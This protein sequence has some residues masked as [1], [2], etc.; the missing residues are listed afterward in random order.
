MIR[1]SLVLVALL[2]AGCKPAAPSAAAP[3]AGHDEHAAP[4]LPP[5]TVELSPAALKNLGVE[6]ATVERRR[7]N[8]LIALP[9]RFDPAPGGRVE[10]RA[11]SAGYL[12]WV[13][14]PFSQV[15]SGE[16]IAL[17]RSP[18]LTALLTEEGDIKS[19]SIQA[20]AK[21]KLASAQL[22]EA[23][24]LQEMRKNRL[25]QLRRLGASRAEQ[26]TQLAEGA[27]AL[28][29]L[30]AELE[31]ARAEASAL[32][33]RVKA[34]DNEV[35]SLAGRRDRIQ[36]DGS[37]LMAAPN[38]GLLSGADV[39]GAAATS[40]ACPDC[41]GDGVGL[42]VT[43]GQ[44]LAFINNERKLQLRVSARP[45]QI[46]GLNLESPGE[47]R[48]HDGHAFPGKLRLDP[49]ADSLTG[50]RSLVCI[51]DQAL[52]A[53]L[54]PGSPANLMVAGLG[55][56][57]EV[58]TIPDSALVRDGSELV[59]FRRDP[60]NPARIRRVVADLG[61]ISAGLAEIKSGLRT[62]DLVVAKGAYAVNLSAAA[63]KNSAPPGFHYHA[64]GQLHSD[65]AEKGGH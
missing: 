63:N 6:F 4:K 57:E 52:P 7:L 18:Q 39:A 29:R 35:I 37:L 23:R 36:E 27:L 12:R 14:K 19:Q 8:H 41:V 2:V 22:A 64:D 21:V 1:H 49:A 54:I 17:L 61:L 32:T 40:C 3:E 28:P 15:K 59:F 13:V 26:E 38:S 5:G 45:D 11:P 34:V 24:A 46:S 62:G 9:G 44:S 65:E 10:I 48:C 58:L 50:A 43:E 33:L 25:D 60:A 47:I 20:E 30:S 55:A 56:A 31:N 42:F 51:P 53:H 16:S